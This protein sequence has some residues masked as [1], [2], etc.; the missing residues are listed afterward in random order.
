MFNKII[1]ILFVFLIV[2]SAMPFITENI[3]ATWWDGAWT[4]MKNCYISPK[5]LKYQS[6]IIVGKTSGGNVTTGG[7]CLDNFGDIRFIHDNTSEIPYWMQNYTSGVQATFWVNNSNNDSCIQMYYGKVGATTT[8]N[9]NTTFEFFDDFNGTARNTHKWNLI[10]TPTLTYSNSVLTCDATNNGK[11]IAGNTGTWGKGYQVV[12][13]RKDYAGLR[14]LGE[15]FNL[16]D[17]G[18]KV[19]AGLF[20]NSATVFDIGWS[21]GTFAQASVNHNNILVYYI[22]SI[23][24]ST[25]ATAHIYS[26][27]NVTTVL[28]AGASS[29]HIPTTSLSPGIGEQYGGAEEK[30]DIDWIFISKFRANAQSCRPAWASFGNEFAGGSVV[31]SNPS[32][33]NG[34]TLVYRKPTLVITGTDTI[35]GH[36]FTLYFMSNG[37]G[38]WSS[39]GTNTSVLDGTYRQ[40]E[41]FANT[42]NKK[43][44]WSVNATDLSTNVWTNATYTFTIRPNYPPTISFTVPV[45]ESITSST[46][47]GMYYSQPGISVT[48]TDPEGDKMNVT[49]KCNNSGSYVK[50]NGISDKNNGTYANTST[51]YTTTNHTYWMSFNFTD[52]HSNWHNFTVRFYLWSIPSHAITTYEN[53]V[54][55]TGTHETQYSSTTGYKVWANYTGTTT[56]INVFDNIGGGITGTHFYKKNSTGYWI[57]ANYSKIS[58]LFN[59]Y[60]NIINATGTLQYNTNAYGTVINMWANYTGNTTA[61]HVTNSTNHA[62]PLHYI[63]FNSTGWWFTDADFTNAGYVN[64]NTN[65]TG[66]S[67]FVFT[68]GYGWT[69]YN[70]YTGITTPI[71]LLEN[72]GYAYGTHIYYLNATGYHVWANYTSNFAHY[73]NIVNATGTHEWQWD[74]RSSTWVVWANYTG[75]GCGATPIHLLENILNASGTH[76]YKINIS[77]YYVYANYTGTGNGSGFNLSNITIDMADFSLIIL[78]ILTLF[79]IFMGYGMRDRKQGAWFL[80]FAGIF[81]IVLMMGVI[82][83]FSGIWWFVSPVMMLFGVIIIRDAWLML[84]HGKKY[85]RK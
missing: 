45:N 66:T 1:T 22:I 10:G 4:Y 18:N 16:T 50:I 57:W 24:R 70:S 74:D 39:V 48:I 65:C 85:G 41:T 6:R 43:Y 13:K 54:N 29:T 80:I 30:A 63:N 55:A 60:Q 19:S 42:F 68:P 73:E 34:A 83:L 5:F 76:V 27:L 26:Y 20:S 46:P 79:F 3:S 72:P 36:Y 56:P 25:E 75:S 8:S 69:L 58:P 78:L 9:G 52:N 37:T 59:L 7:H 62:V 11:Y 14:T 35:A 61:L 81:Y 32:P 47:V 28:Y 17:G 49:Y 53:I 82:A 64:Y 31:Q 44:W 40:Y 15:G 12:T 2:F 77:G 23:C 84:I 21:D 33:T 38:S 67:Y 51:Y 71:E